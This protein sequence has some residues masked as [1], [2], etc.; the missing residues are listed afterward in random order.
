[1]AANRWLQALPVVLDPHGHAIIQYLIIGPQ[2][3]TL[4]LYFSS[5]MPV[6]PFFL[7]QIGYCPPYW[8]I[9]DE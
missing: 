3:L 2:H 1:M 6:L 5:H 7:Y 4:L 9:K 8:L